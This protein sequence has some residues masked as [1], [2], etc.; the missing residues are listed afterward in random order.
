MRKHNPTYLGE[1]P[2]SLT[3][4]KLIPNLPRRSQI[5][6]YRFILEL[7]RKLPTNP[8]RSKYVFDWG[9]PTSRSWPRTMFRKVTA[10]GMGPR[11]TGPRRGGMGPGLRHGPYA[12]GAPPHPPGVP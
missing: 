10:H 4:P 8:T 1:A 12:E 9:L 7:G 6:A 5:D 2:F 3:D 11:G